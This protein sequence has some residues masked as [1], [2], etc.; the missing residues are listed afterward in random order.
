MRWR[1]RNWPEREPRPEARTLPDEEKTKRLAAM[2]KEVAASPVLTGLELRVRSQRGRFYLERPLG[3][4]DSAGV[5]VWGRITPLADSPD[6]L[7]EQEG[8]KG[9]WSEIARGS[10][11]KLIKTVA[12]DTKGTFHG[13]GAL[14]KALRRAGK[15]LE[16][17]PVKR[18]GTTFVYAE[19]GEVCSPQEALFHYFGLPLHVLVEPSEWYSYHRKPMIIDNDST[20]G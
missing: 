9:I 17:V 14:D 6:L 16:R 8:R 2:T 15:G 20:L 13:M 11:R 7:L 19:S 10:S 12:S 3:E 18:E 5:E 4:G 1:H